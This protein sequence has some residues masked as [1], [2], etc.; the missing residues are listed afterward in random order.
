MRRVLRPVTPIIVLSLL[1]GGL[2]SAGGAAPA[3]AGGSEVDGFS[4]GVWALYYNAA[5]DGSGT[6]PSGSAFDGAG[7]YQGSGT[8]TV[9]GAS[10]T[11]GTFTGHGIISVFVEAPTGTTAGELPIVAEGIVAGT[12]RA[13]NMEG[14]F[15]ARGS[16]NIM[17]DLISLTVP[18]SLAWEDRYP[19]DILIA[20]CEWVTGEWTSQIRSEGAAA[21]GISASG[22]ASFSAFRLGAEVGEADPFLADVE[23]LLADV[24]AFRAMPVP[25]DPDGVL[26]W[27]IA[28]LGLLDRAEVLLGGVPTLEE[29]AGSESGDDF[30]TILTHAIG[31]LLRT[32]L[33]GL[34]TYGGTPAQRAQLLADL[35]SAG[36]RTGAIGA[37]STVE[38]AAALEADLIAAMDA[39]LTDAIAAGDGGTIATVEAYARSFGWSALAARAGSAP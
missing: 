4:D 16:F 31:Q 5:L 13:P 23:D 29:C 28:L 24:E 8:F 6:L 27:D 38:G 19:M 36:Y 17:T 10:V 9:R 15:S 1:G 34:A 39:V 20:E 2:V 12:A 22:P 30:T 32:E 7:S 35:A 3:A 26:G 33:D 11:D 18:V 14:Q 25:G 37:G 21:T